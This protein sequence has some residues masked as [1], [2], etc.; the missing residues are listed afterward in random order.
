VSVLISPV[1]KA[2]RQ[3]K[4]CFQNRNL[5]IFSLLLAGLVLVFL[6]NIAMGSVKISL[7][8]VADI[9]I[10]NI[11]DDSIN[12][13]IVWTMRLPRSLAAVMGGAALAVAG[14]L[15]QIFFR[16]P[17]A[18]SYVL[19]ISAGSMLVMALLVLGGFK[20]GISSLPIYYLFIGAFLGALIVTAI[21]LVFAYFVRNIVT[22][23]V[24]GLMIGYLCSA[25]TGLLVTFGD[26]E[27]VKGFVVWAM[28]SFAGFT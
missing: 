3:P 9:I 10:K 13:T 15:L 24:I 6:L 16:N 11:R 2:A 14:L 25:A 28:G 8:E 27:K 1:Q 20:L 26:N 4:R 5:I 17:I 18:D 7:P 23:L 21:V 12:S 22:L 19:G